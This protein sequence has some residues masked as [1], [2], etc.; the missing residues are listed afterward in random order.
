MGL[1]KLASVYGEVAAAGVGYKGAL[2]GHSSLGQLEYSLQQ[3]EIVSLCSV[4]GPL[5][6]MLIRGRL[7]GR[8]GGGGGGVG[9]GGQGVGVML[10]EVTLMSAPH[11][12]FI[13]L[14]VSS[15][16]FFFFKLQK[17]LDTE[18]IE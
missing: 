12:L 14:N 11:L 6:D 2:G 10:D 17:H 3:G 4:P 15:I 7:T 18:K 8:E 1:E 9:W 16:Q 13:H 5:K